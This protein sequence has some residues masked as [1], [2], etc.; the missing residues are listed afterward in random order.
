MGDLIHIDMEPTGA[1]RE[2]L[3][4]DL[5]LALVEK[6]E[7]TVGGILELATQL[8]MQHGLRNAAKFV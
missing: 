5:I 7:L 8:A 1:E 4:L 2:E 3:L 6:H